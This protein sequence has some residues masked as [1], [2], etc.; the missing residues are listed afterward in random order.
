ML[1]RARF[2]FISTGAYSQQVTASNNAAFTKPSTVASPTALSNMV[3]ME[4]FSS[5]TYGPYMPPNSISLAQNLMQGVPNFLPISAQKMAWPGT[6]GDSGAGWTYTE[7]TLIWI[8]WWTW[9]GSAAAHMVT[10]MPPN[11]ISFAQ[12]LGQSDKL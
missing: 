12:N 5:I 7:L 9:N 2:K 11:S 6:D 4:W 3:D 10:F 1:H 8:I